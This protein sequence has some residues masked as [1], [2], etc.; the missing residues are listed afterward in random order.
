MGRRLVS[1]EHLNLLTLRCSDQ[2][3]VV[4]VSPLRVDARAPQLIHAG[5]T[6]LYAHQEAFERAPIAHP[7][8]VDVAV[9]AHRHVAVRRAER[10]QGFSVGCAVDEVDDIVLTAE[11]C[12][13]GLRP[14]HQGQLHPSARVV[15]PSVPEIDHVTRGAAVGIAKCKGRKIVIGDHP[16]RRSSRL[17]RWHA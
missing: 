10:Q 14:V 5:V 1:A 13:L 16:Q 3:C 17:H 2:F 6:C 15:R 11:Q 9:D 4:G 7:L 8:N 12:A